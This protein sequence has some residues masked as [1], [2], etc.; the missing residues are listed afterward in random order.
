MMPTEDAIAVGEEL[1]RRFGVPA[2]Q[3]ALSATDAN[4]FALRMARQVQ[5]RSKI[6]I[7]LHAYHGTV[8]ETVATLDANGH[9]VPREGNVGAPVDPALTTKVV[10]FNDL[11]AVRAALAPRDV[12]VVLAEPAMTNVGMV[13][14][15]RRV[16]E[17]VGGGVRRDRHAADLRRDPHDVDGPGRLRARVGPDAGRGHARQ[18]ARRRRPDR[19]LRAE[20]GAARPRRRRPRGRLP[21]LGRRRR[22]A[23]RQRAVARRRARDA[24]RRPHRRGLHLDAAHLRA[25]RR[26]RR[27]RSSPSTARRGTSSASARA[28]SSATRPRRTP[29]APTRTTRSTR[30]STTSSTPRCSTAA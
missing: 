7:F 20:R 16:P 12:A 6:M 26:G 5:Q 19:R 15:A 10:P 23:G 2:W 4:R 8:D 27:A 14:P 3:F 30:C 24:D 28:P 18:G 29:P 25:L 17:G 9:V 13:L 21:G 11:D 1:G 22:H